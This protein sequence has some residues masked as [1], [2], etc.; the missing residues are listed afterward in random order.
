LKGSGL[1]L[2]FER[3]DTFTSEEAL[4]PILLT[5]MTNAERDVHPSPSPV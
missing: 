2:E 1:P 3:H 5:D 4:D